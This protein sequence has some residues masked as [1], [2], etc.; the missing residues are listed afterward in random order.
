MSGNGLGRLFR[1]AVTLLLP[2]AVLV[3]S[4]EIR[5]SEVVKLATIRGSIN[6]ASADFLIQ[7]IRESEDDSAKALLIELDTPGG[8]VSSTKDI[9]QA[10]LNSNVAVI[11]YVAPRGARDSLR[12]RSRRDLSLIH[13]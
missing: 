1:A 5:A 7:A 3:Q 4:P 6:P 12:L 11:V 2:F 10:I 9:I 13:I 8:L